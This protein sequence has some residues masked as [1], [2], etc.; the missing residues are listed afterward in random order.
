MAVTVLQVT[1]LTVA[2]AE[3]M[4]DGI[5]AKCLHQAMA[6]LALHGDIV[7]KG[8]QVWDPCSVGQEF[9]LVSS[10]LLYRIIIAIRT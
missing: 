2:E 3:L 10:P 8:A 5:E 4:K 7:T 9:G 1:F 6:L